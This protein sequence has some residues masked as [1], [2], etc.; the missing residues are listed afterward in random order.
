MTT[1][2]SVTSALKR[3]LGRIRKVQAPL[4]LRD[5]LVFGGIGLAAYGAGLILPAYGYLFLG[6]TLMAIGL[7]GR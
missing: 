3:A 2:K 6:V 5:V 4:S 7:W 1:V